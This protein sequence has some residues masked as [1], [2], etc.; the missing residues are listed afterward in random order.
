MFSE[1]EAG[2]ELGKVNEMLEDFEMKFK[3]RS[4]EVKAVFN[5]MKTKGHENKMQSQIRNKQNVNDQMCDT[6]S[7]QQST[8]SDGPANSPH[9]QKPKLNRMVSV[10][11]TASSEYKK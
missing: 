2:K 11:F 9:S 3:S 6:L 4:L 10:Y 1:K 5:D 7:S 8:A